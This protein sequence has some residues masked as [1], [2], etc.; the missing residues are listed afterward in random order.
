[1][2]RILFVFTIMVV[3]MFALNSSVF[4]QTQ[5]AVVP[6]KVEYVLPYPGILSDNPLY[7]LKNLRD[8]I[9]EMLIVD[10]S[11]KAEFY[12]LQSDKDFNAGIFLQA[13]GKTAPAITTLTRG[14]TYTGNSIS[15]A[16]S[17]KLL[18]K[19]LPVYTLDRLQKSIAKHQEV[20]VDMISS[21]PDDQKRNF[22]T[23]LTTV[24][25]FTEDVKEI[26]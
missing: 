1:M 10:P 23:I 15:I 6:Q 16:A 2:K 5:E 12:I 19:P 3:W 9:M 14:N 21:V 26:R 20:V 11:K 4:A 7:V 25:K 24:K 13:K 8:K 17:Q 22:E 18:G